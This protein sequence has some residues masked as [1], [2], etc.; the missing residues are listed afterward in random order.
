MLQWS[1]AAAGTR[2]GSLQESVADS[3]L[4]PSTEELLA[5]FV[6]EGERGNDIAAQR[7][8][9][10]GEPNTSA[11]RS[12]PRCVTVGGYASTQPAWEARFGAA[13]HGHL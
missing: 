3:G 7:L 4:G 2:H 5:D 1:L 13:G 10:D 12:A 8:A 11:D 9:V 6:A